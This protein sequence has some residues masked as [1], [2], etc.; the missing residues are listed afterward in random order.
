M[1]TDPLAHL[2]VHNFERMGHVVVLDGCLDVG[3]VAKYH[4]TPVRLNLRH[5]CPEADLDS[6]I[7]TLSKTRV[8][9]K[10]KIRNA[11]QV[12]APTA[13]APATARTGPRKKFV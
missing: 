9:L 13:S 11:M 5:E 8:A 2:S 6:I 1:P 10:A 12:S 3:T 4:L 7:D